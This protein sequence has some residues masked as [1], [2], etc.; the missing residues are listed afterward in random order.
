MIQILADDLLLHLASFLP[1]PDLLRLSRASRRI[2]RALA[3]PDNS[4]IVAAIQRQWGVHFAVWRPLFAACSPSFLLEAAAVCHALAALCGCWTLTN[5]DACS[6][7]VRGG[8][9]SVLPTA[10]GLRV[11]LMAPKRV[12]L[13]HFE[14]E[15]SHPLEAVERALPRHAPFALGE[16]I[17][18]AYLV[19]RVLPAFT[20]DIHLIL[21]SDG[22]APLQAR[23]VGREYTADGDV[24]SSSVKSVGCLDLLRYEL[25]AY[26]RASLPHHAVFYPTSE[27]AL[28]AVQPPTP[29]GARVASGCGSPEPSEAHVAA[30]AAMRGTTRHGLTRTDFHVLM[31][32][33]PS[34]HA[35]PT[36]S[37]PARCSACSQA[38]PS[39]GVR[40]HPR[41][42]TCSLDN[43]PLRL[44]VRFTSDTACCLAFICCTATLPCFH[45][46]DLVPVFNAAYPIA[47]PWLPSASPAPFAAPPSQPA[48]LPPA[49]CLC[50]VQ[51]L[52]AGA[53]GPHGLEIVCLLQVGVPPRV[54]PCLSFS[55]H[56]L[57]QSRDR[58]FA[59]K[60]T[61]DPNIP[62]GQVSFVVPTQ[63]LLMRPP[64]LHCG[65]R[66]E[67]GRG[68]FG[69]QDDDTD[70][71]CPSAAARASC[72]AG[73]WMLFC[74]SRDYR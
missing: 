8:I 6:S 3:S 38:L 54:S 5:V 72:I 35:S 7:S 65:C 47:A 48:L 51:G 25:A 27:A 67:V 13:D 42:C 73:V 16:A 69:A 55:P 26:A 32:H 31:E 70:C 62:A 34:T 50:G 39:H 12:C 1:V 14:W 19:D 58:M 56:A 43:R 36:S 60:V 66:G 53:Y 71:N 41:S 61:G 21:P 59:I 64:A 30:D 28:H 44:N 4:L 46:S 23:V 20:L 74:C 37:L 11:C 17:E 10:D 45:S 24:A 33:L 22:A 9:C 52:W 15:G 29:H 18:R 57:T 63:P 2:R 49:A 40:C 68:M